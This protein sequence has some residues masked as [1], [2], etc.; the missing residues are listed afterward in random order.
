MAGGQV[1]RPGPDR[2]KGWELLNA[3]GRGHSGLE[4]GQGRE[5][6][7]SR[8]ESPPRRHKRKKLALIR[9][10][11]HV[12]GGSEWRVV[13][14]LAFSASRTNE[15]GGHV[16]SPLGR[17]PSGCVWACP[18]R[19]L[20]SCARGCS[21]GTRGPCPD[22]ESSSDSPSSIRSARL[23]QGRTDVLSNTHVPRLC[24]RRPSSE[25]ALVPGGVPPRPVP[26][27]VP[28]ILPFLPCACCSLSHFPKCLIAAEPVGHPAFGRGGGLWPMVVG[29]TGR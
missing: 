14:E 8:G 15:V 17:V 28:G 1:H 21:P 10:L 13:G 27:R 16:K 22:A 7:E 11:D 29:E 20:S 3:P 18:G 25:S 26:E 12:R 19:G 2:V 6:A 4:L 9:V 5:I 23:Q 24:L